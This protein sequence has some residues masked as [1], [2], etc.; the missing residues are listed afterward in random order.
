MTGEERDRLGRAGWEAARAVMIDSG[1]P[2]DWL[3]GDW[4]SLPDSVRETYRAAADAAAA[5]V[6]AAAAPPVCSE[7]GGCRDCH[8][9]CYMYIYD[10]D[11]G[12]KGKMPCPRCES[13]GRISP[14]VVAAAAPP[15]KEGGE[16]E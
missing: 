15:A 13:A 4:N 7:C 3:V 10:P 12:I 1:I 5:A 14:G 16:R 6:V 8:G 9:K 11:V 2:D